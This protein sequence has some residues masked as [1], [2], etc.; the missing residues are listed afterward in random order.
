MDRDLKSEI[1]SFVLI[2]SCE[3]NSELNS[4]CLTIW[5]S[6]ESGVR[7]SSTVVHHKIPQSECFQP[8]AMLRQPYYIRALFHRNERPVRLTLRMLLLFIVVFFFFT[9]FS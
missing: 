3:F 1:I 6:L 5:F 8:R 9:Y 2:L 7:G 4:E